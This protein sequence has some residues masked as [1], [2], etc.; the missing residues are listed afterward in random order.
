MSAV[1][2]RPDS[3]CLYSKLPKNSAGVLPWRRVNSAAMSG[4]MLRIEV[5]IE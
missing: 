5:F 3:L 4:R 2:W 1:T